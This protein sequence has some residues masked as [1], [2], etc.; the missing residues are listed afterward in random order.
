M[1]ARVAPISRMRCDGAPA[2]RWPAFGDARHSPAVARTNEA[3]LPTFPGTDRPNGVT[4]ATWLA[5]LRRLLRQ[6]GA[7]EAFQAGAQ[8]G[9]LDG[10]QA[11]AEPGDIR[12]IGRLLRR[13]VLRPPPHQIGR[14]HV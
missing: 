2:Q 9:V 5:F 6:N 3:A 11:L 14:A 8:L 4:R 12:G 13:P 7:A 1:V 10:G